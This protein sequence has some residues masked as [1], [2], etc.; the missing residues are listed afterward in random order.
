MRNNLYHPTEL[1]IIIILVP[2]QLQKY[3]IS[4]EF[5]WWAAVLTGDSDFA[6]DFGQKLEIEY[7]GVGDTICGPF[8]IHPLIPHSSNEFINIFPSESPMEVL[9][10]PPSNIKS[11]VHKRPVL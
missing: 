4:K 10:G 6:L 11:P 9:A 5:Q 8:L 7:R 2:E 3:K 1:E